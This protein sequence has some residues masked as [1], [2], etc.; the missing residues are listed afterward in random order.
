MVSMKNWHF[1][2]LRVIQTLFKSAE[3]S[4]VCGIYFPVVLEN[5]TILYKE[6][7]AI[8]QLTVARITSVVL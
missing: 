4:R 2:S 6:T 1:L 3:T 8:C 7:N 5:I